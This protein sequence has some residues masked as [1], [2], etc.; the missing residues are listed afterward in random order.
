MLSLL[1]VSL[2]AQPLHAA[3]ADDLHDLRLL[4]DHVKRS[5]SLILLQSKKVLERPWVIMELYTAIRNAVP[6]V[7]RSLVCGANTR[8]G[9]DLER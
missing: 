9:A 2:L 5:K 7:A 4:L 8:A 3:R 6:I 1:T